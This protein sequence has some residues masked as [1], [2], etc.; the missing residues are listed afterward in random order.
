MTSASALSAVSATAGA[1]LTVQERM[2]LRRSLRTA[3]KEVILR[4]CGRTA[5]IEAPGL[6]SVTSP[7]PD[8]AVQKPQSLESQSSGGRNHDLKRAAWEH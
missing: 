2:R 7:S 5:A 6:M 1:P 3:G 4:S 8:S